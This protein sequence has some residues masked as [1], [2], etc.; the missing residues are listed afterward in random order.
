MPIK[1]VLKKIKL[2]KD[3][4]SFYALIPK[5]WIDELGLQLDKELYIDKTTGTNPLA[6]EIKI[7]PKPSSD[8]N[9]ESSGKGKSKHKP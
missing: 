7:R 4:Y 1:S 6:W 8:S 2:K 9:I 5:E 3:H